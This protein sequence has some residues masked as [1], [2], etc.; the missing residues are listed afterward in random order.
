MSSIA[1]LSIIVFNG[2]LCSK[3]ITFKIPLIVH[4]VMSFWIDLDLGEACYESFMDIIIFLMHLILRM[5]V[6]FDL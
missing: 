4:I 3:S 2:L 6:R 5:E 1:N